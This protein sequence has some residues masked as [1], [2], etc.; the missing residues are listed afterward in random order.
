MKVCSDCHQHYFGIHC[1]GC[2]CKPKH[3]G[4]LPIGALLGITMMGCNVVRGDMRAAYGAEV[5]ETDVDEDGYYADMEDCDDNDPNT[6]PGAAI[7]DSDTACM[8]D[9][10]GDGYGDANPENEMVEPGTDC[11]DT[12]PEVNPANGNC[13]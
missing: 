1:E 8:T 13:E 6:F 9:A 5:V 7:E 2:N 12:D 4:T 3:T 11:D 10:D